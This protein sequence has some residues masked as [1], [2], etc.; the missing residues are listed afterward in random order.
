MLLGVAASA[1]SAGSTGSVIINGPALLNTNYPSVST[2][3]AFDYTGQGVF[4]NKGTV[5]G[6]AVSLRGLE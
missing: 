6:R 2:P 4:G 1:A 5:A 3:I